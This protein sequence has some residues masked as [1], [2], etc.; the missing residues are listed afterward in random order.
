M[1]I[2]SFPSYIKYPILQVRYFFGKHLL[3]IYP[4]KDVGIV[5]SEK[6]AI[7][8]GKRMSLN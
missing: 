7:I 4:N 3:K 2:K 5:E 1:T 8:A 6:S